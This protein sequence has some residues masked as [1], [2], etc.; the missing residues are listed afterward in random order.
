MPK[1]SCPAVMVGKSGV[2]MNLLP[3]EFLRGRRIFAVKREGQIDSAMSCLQ[4]L[5]MNTSDFLNLILEWFIKFTGKK[6][7][8]ILRQ[9]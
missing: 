1:F 4:I 5:V 7:A 2:A 8:S 9:E 3:S 6:R